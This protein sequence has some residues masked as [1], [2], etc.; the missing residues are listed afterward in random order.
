MPSAVVD[1]EADAGRADGPPEP[2]VGENAGVIAPWLI[3]GAGGQVG[4]QV[5]RALT[6]RGLPVVGLTRAD[7]DISNPD[8][9]TSALT[10][11]CPAVVINAAAYTAVDRAESEVDTATAINA[12]APGLLAHAALSVGAGI[13]HLSTDYVFNGRAHRPYRPEDAT[14]PLSVYGSTKRAG[15]LAVLRA[16]PGAHVV[17]TA[18]VYGRMGT[19]FPRTIARV[20][21]QQGAAEVVADQIGSP[22]W[23]GDL[24]T[25]LIALVECAPEPG[26]YHCTGGGETS[27]F[28]F[29]QAVAES[30]GMD[31]AVVTAR[32]T[33]VR[34]RPA[35][36]P[37]YS[38]LDMTQWR[39]VGLPSM[40]SWREAWQME[41]S[42]AVLA[43]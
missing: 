18:W 12:I 37:M 30:M 10:S 13:V 38:V 28:G 40:R 26:I 11:I 35:T 8:A 6:E 25:A 36:R 15:E 19:C 7:L 17:R 27:W 34:E 3:T 21:R 2:A 14:D 31:P 42:D 5:V 22:T 1:C 16:H 20:I 29:A 41:G 9:V 23:A 24:A 33:R 4:G 39:A 43:G 32:T